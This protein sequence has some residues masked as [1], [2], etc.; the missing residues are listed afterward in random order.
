[1]KW[2]QFAPTTGFAAALVVAANVAAQ[3]TTS[4]AELSLDSLLNTRISTASKYSQTTAEAPASVTILT[5]DEIKQFGYRDLLEALESVPGFYGSNDRNYP[6][7]GTRGFGRPTDYN[8]RIL[9]L[10]DGQT[11]NEEMWGSAYVGSDFPINLDAV[12]RIEV[13]RGPSSTLYGTSAMFAVVNIITKTGIRLDGLALSGRMGSA[14]TRELGMTAGRALGSRGS[15]AASGL[16]THRAGSD[17]FFPEYDAPETNFGIA[18]GTDWEHSIGGLTS[19][20]WGIFKGH[21]GY[22]SRAKGIPTG[23]YGTK[24]DDPSVSTVD[25]SLWG[26]IGMERELGPTFRVTARLYADRYRYSGLYP[27]DSGPPDSDGARTTQI[28]GE[29]MLIWEASSRNRLTV[30]TELRR[31]PHAVYYEQRPDGLRTR[32]DEPFSVASVFAEDEFQLFPRVSLVAGVR[33]DEN[34]RGRDAT[35]PRFALVATPDRSTTIK[36]LYGHA[37]R[38]PSAAEANITSSFYVQN[39][40]IRPEQNRTLEVDVQRRL[41]SP[42]MIG[43]S[44][45]EYRLRD[46]IDQVDAGNGAVRFENID[47]SRAAGVELQLDALPSGP[48]TGRVAYA[49]Q[50]VE[51]D[52]SGETL[53]NSPQQIARFALASKGSFGIRPAVEVRYESGRRTI[54]GP[55]TSA[56]TRTDL[57]VGYSPPSLSSV[58]WLRG[59]EL[60]LRVTNVFDISYA[61]PGG[62]EHR[63]SAITQ[64]GRTFL[65]R[66]DW[67]H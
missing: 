7:L 57:N 28:G 27:G 44:L 35:T 65:F 32:D 45:F 39:P 37:Y 13:V 54:A 59:A 50:R 15:I 66:L 64:D 3:T 46:L 51:T 56:F 61:T 9:L 30:G 52:P 47:A 4:R 10:V 14:G 60:S 42:L 31:I 21:I 49:F 22:R 67:Q 8:N 12:D 25:E 41:G 38:A 62:V 2:I 18:H 55:S 53:T 36:A 43:M 1:M 40:T 29:G 11:L 34:F 19:M 48:V 6:Y 24:F 16:V 26:Q 33:V 5:S 17:L 58:R 20:S 23:A 63:Q